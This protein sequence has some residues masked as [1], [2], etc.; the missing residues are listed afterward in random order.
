MNPTQT[1]NHPHATQMLVFDID[2]VLTNPRTMVFNGAALTRIAHDLETRIPVAFNTGRST[3]WV[4]D[5]VMPLLMKSIGHDALSNLLVVAEKGGVRVIFQDGTPQI[6]EDRTLSLPDAFVHDVRQLLVAPL[7]DGGQL[8]RTVFWD[9]GKRTMGSVEKLPEAPM[10][11]YTDARVHLREGLER[12]LVAHD[13]TQFKI[14]ETTIATDIEH[15]SAGK[16]KGAEKILE[17]LTARHQSIDT[18]YSFG[19]SASDEIMAQVFGEHGY[20]STFVYVGQAPL[21][22]QTSASYK[23]H[24]L[25]GRFD[26]DTADFLATIL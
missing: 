22:L 8:S 16:H 2:G 14:D 6:E 20:A 19:D 11:Q 23:R 3:E 13:L 18:I 10:E 7:P 24:V 25:H 12:L 26:A 21:Q 4:M 9:E 5:R 1:S 17:W 15:H